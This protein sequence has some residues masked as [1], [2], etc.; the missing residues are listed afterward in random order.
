MNFEYPVKLRE[1]PT[2]EMAPPLPDTALL[3]VK[4]LFP[5]KYT[6]EFR[7]F[8]PDS[9]NVQFPSIEIIVS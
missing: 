8:M 3:L 4:V 2:R 5:F 9:M 1:E 6:L 7:V